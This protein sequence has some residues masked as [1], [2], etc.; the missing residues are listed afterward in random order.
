MLRFFEQWRNSHR[1]NLSNQPLNIPALFFFSFFLFW[2]TFP[3]SSPWCL[4]CQISISFFLRNW[5]RGGGGDFRRY[6]VWKKKT[7][8]TNKQCHTRLLEN[9]LFFQTQFHIHIHIHISINATVGVVFFE[10]IK[11]DV[12][13]STFLQKY[14]EIGGYS[15]P[16]RKGLP[17]GLG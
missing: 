14:S 15:P 3:S 9:Q 10:I 5:T 6:L 4:T 13:I 2:N 16:P 7:K 17:W 12:T 1:L 11:R 8:K